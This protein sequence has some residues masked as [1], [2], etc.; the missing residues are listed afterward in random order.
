MAGVQG[1]AGVMQGS[2]GGY[3]ADSQILFG[4]ILVQARANQ[5]ARSSI[6]DGT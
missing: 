3:L 1:I 4:D 6:A 5:Y 2:V